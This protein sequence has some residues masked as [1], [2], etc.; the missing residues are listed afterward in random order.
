MGSPVGNQG[1]IRPAL[2]F[3]PQG[4]QARRNLEYSPTMQGQCFAPDSMKIARARLK[5]DCAGV[6]IQ[7][8]R[9]V[10]DSSLMLFVQ[11][12]RL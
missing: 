8:C 6:N 1:K 2:I 11:F 9:F 10:L 5:G 3:A 4:M 12:E 7:P